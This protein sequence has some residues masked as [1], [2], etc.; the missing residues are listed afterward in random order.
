MSAEINEW[1]TRY[2]IGS[3]GWDRGATSHNLTYWFGGDYFSWFTD[4]KFDVVFEQT[5]SVPC[6]P[7]FGSVLI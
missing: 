3:T 1:E 4:E 6:R 7:S 2:Q 5:A